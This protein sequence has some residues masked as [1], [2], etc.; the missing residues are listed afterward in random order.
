M[1]KRRWVG[2]AEGENRSLAAAELALNNPLIDDIC[3]VQKAR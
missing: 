1:V 2:E 3:K